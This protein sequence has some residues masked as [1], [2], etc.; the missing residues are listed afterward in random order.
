LGAHWAGE[1]RIMALSIKDK[2]FAD[3]GPNFFARQT[4]LVIIDLKWLVLFARKIAG[5][6]PI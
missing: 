4:K 6:D 2:P 1:R 3:A 5:F